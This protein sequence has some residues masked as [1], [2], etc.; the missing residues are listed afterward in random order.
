MITLPE[1]QSPLEKTGTLLSLRQSKLIVKLFTFPSTMVAKEREATETLKL[2]KESVEK[3]VSYEKYAGFRHR[4]VS[5]PC[6]K[7]W[8]S[9]TAVH[10]DVRWLSNSKG[11]CYHCLTQSWSLVK[12]KET[13]GARLTLRDRLWKTTLVRMRRVSQGPPSFRLLEPCVAPFQMTSLV[14]QLKDCSKKQSAVR[15]LYNSTTAGCCNTIAIHCI[16]PLCFTWS[17]SNALF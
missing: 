17:D 4:L 3:I 8:A 6:K 1:T 5:L 12:D 7:Q 10:W 9:L 13:P 11:C 14:K 2:K 16:I 15:C